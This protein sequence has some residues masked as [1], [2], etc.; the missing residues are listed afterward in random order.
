MLTIPLAINL[1]LLANPKNAAA[2]EKKIINIEPQITAPAIPELNKIIALLSF[3]LIS[4]I[5]E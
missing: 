4:V 3:F 1:I 2:D 5:Y